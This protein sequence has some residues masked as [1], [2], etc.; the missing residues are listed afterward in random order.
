MLNR[1]T[2]R[3]LFAAHHETLHQVEAG[4]Q[5]T[6]EHSPEA[7]RRRQQYELFALHMRL[8][9]VEHEADQARHAY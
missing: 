5:E 6:P 1:K 2:L 3:K 4:P 7:Q 9:E 8:V